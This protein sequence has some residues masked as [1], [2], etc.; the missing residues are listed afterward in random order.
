MASL[1]VLGTPLTACSYVPLTGY[2]RT[3]S[4]ESC[5]EDVGQH[6]VCVLMD[7]EFLAFC[8]IV[9]NDL[10]TP[11]PEYGFFGLHPGDRWCLCASR[12]LEA[13]ASGCAPR[14]VLAASHENLLERVSLET[15][16]DY[17]VD[18]PLPGSAQG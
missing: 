15:L 12:W 9:G 13:L 4:C 7:E 5:A 1:N 18:W 8:Q 14:L 2:F 16:L 10:T 6:T 11:R 17:A 3:G